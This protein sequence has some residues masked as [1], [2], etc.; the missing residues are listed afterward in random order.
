MSISP[1]VGDA[2]ENLD[3]SNMQQGHDDSWSSKGE[4]HKFSSIPNDTCV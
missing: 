2:Q 1:A 3:K 4:E